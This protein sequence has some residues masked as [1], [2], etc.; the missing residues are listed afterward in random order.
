MPLTEEENKRKKQ[1]ADEIKLQELRQILTGMPQKEL[2]K[3]N[4]FVQ[5][6]ESLSNEISALL[7]MSVKK[8]IDNREVDLSDLQPVIEDILKESVRKNPH[9]L[10]DILFP[11]MMPA[12]RKAVA[13]DIKKMLDSVNTTLEH[14]FSPKRIGWRLQALFSG[15][16]YAEIALS[17]AYIYQVKE[18]FLIHK[19][20]GLLLSHVS[21]SE[22]RENSADMVSS[23]LSAIK[24]F[25]Q[26]SFK[27]E[28]DNELQTLK[29][30]KL[31]ILIEQ[32]P[33]AIIASVVEGNVPDEYKTL[34]KETIERIHISHSYELEHFQGDT[35]PFEADKQLLTNCLQ[36]EVKEQKRKKPVFAIIILLL[37]ALAL[38]YLLYGYI[39]TRI[40][41]NGL[42]KQIRNEKGLVITEKGK[43]WFGKYYLY[44]LNDASAVNPYVFVKK[45]K[46]DTS[47]LIMKFKPFF[48][49]D[50]NFVLK[51]A[52]KI[53]NPPESVNLK[54]KN[55]ILSVNG[56][57]KRQWLDEVKKKWNLIYGVNSVKYNVAVSDTLKPVLTKK[58]KKK[59][60]VKNI[61]AIE[62]HTFTFKYNVFELTEKQS[63]EFD[64][65]INEVNNVLNFSFDQDSVPV[66]IVNSYTSYQGNT[67]ANKI[68][69]KHRAEQFINMMIEKGI[70]ME[71]LVPKV[72]FIEDE[73]NKYPIRTVSFK[74]KYVKPESL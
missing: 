32:G 41:F 14:S 33:Y 9:T 63:E 67:E 10:S 5:N 72:K 62:K 3:L 58:E 25:V 2:E 40:R 46:M 19:Q 7:P 36:K 53:L 34:L 37:I 73:N 70:P 57:C 13:E 48:S 55:G 49:A 74:V 4:R 39:E 68:V 21:H 60:V 23:M 43:H 51:R 47:R 18:V 24:D 12:I 59:R 20:T 35:A 8:L 26:D 38:A 42:V 50:E 66:I 27:N 30:G 1:A 54:L 11:I 29:I 28:D 71:T 16:S 52:Y 45:S 64:K 22:Q 44:G 69:A 15:K 61:L 17:H 6:P 31:N 56:S 65:L